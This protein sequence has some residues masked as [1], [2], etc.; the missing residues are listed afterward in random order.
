MILSPCTEKRRAETDGL[1]AVR[2]EL[3]VLLLGLPC[4]GG[5]GRSL[6]SRPHAIPVILDTDIGGDVDDAWALAFLLA[7]PELDV[8][9]IVSDSR[10]TV[11]KARIIAEFLQ[12]AGRVDIPIGIGAR[13]AGTTS[14][15][16]WAAAYPGKVHADGV[17]ALIDT[18][19][20]SRTPVTLVA[21]GPVGNLEVALEREPRIVNHARLIVMGG[22]IGKQEQGE[23]G[24]LE[25]NVAQ[26]PKAAQK[27]YAAAWDV[28]MTPTDTAGKVQLEGEDY[29]RVRDA[30]NPMARLVMEQYRLWNQKQT[31][32]ARD[33]SRTSSTL[34]DTVAIY[35]AFDQGFCRMRDIKL[36]VTDKGITQP[37]PDGKLTHV[38]IEWKGLGAF[39]KLL[40]ERIATFRP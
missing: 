32:H 2:A 31:K 38:A 26:N 7:C 6:V 19:M 33:I 37:S 25:Y 8:K 40:A 14:S 34:W 28:T 35:L 5:C 11:E 12:A 9:L 30:D 27:A 4:L 3:A 29:A 23:P 21:I 18:I 1:R 10:N 16:S 22:S 15:E 20:A 39:H 24:F 13:S 17:Q 36:R